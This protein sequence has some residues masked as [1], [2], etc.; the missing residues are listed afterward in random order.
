MAT[1]DVKGGA[2]RPKKGQEARCASAHSTPM[3]YIGT[4]GWSNPPA[5]KKS[6]P[7]GW[8]HLEH[9]AANFSCVEINSSF[10]RPHRQDTYSRWR[11]TTPRSFRFAVKMPRSVT[12]EGALKGTRREIREFFGGVEALGPK[13]AVILIQLPPS[14]EFSAALVRRFFTS[15]PR[16]DS[17]HLACEPRHLSW[18]AA[19]ADSILAR[20]NVCRVAADPAI[21]PAAKLPGGA[22]DFAYFRWHGSPRKYYSSYA[23]AELRALAA[24]VRSERG[25]SWCVFDNTARYAAWDNAISLKSLVQAAHRARRNRSAISRGRAA[26]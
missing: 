9:Y 19:K 13:L 17:V 7:T 23:T 20:L 21:A 3:I 1:F 15:L 16:L 26:P 12:H 8:T 25:N 6:R 10:Y 5:Q 4:A 11:D 24:S 14:L 18:F 2:R 22:S